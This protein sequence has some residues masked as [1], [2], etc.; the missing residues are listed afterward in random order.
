VEQVVFAD[1]TG[2]ERSL[3]T[4]TVVSAVGF[5]GPAALVPDDA[6]AQDGRLG[7]GLYRVGW[8]RRGARGT[9]PEARADARLVAGVVVDDLRAQSPSPRRSGPDRCFAALPATDLA[10][11]QAIERHERAT[12]AHGRVRNKV[13]D[14]GE[15]LQLARPHLNHL[16]G[17]PA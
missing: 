4:D 13:T 6:P 7:A 16:E 2:S 3:V 15:L 12:A 5:T 1:P 14:R 17:E 9:I 11:W 10:G 8:A